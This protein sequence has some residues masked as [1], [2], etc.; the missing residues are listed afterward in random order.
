MEL[1][2]LQYFLAVTRE[3]SI[4]SAAQSLHLSQPTLSRQLK[5]LENELGKTLFIRSNRK[6]TLT[7]EGII[8]R[9]RAEEILELIQKAQNEI[10]LSDQLIAGNLYI[11]AGETESVRELAQ[12]AQLLQQKHPMIQFHI[13]SGDRTTVLDD[14]DH[15]M[16][17]FALVF[18]E[19]DPTRY[20]SLILPQ[21]DCFG[22]LMQKSDPLAKKET[23]TPED[24]M[25]KPL[26]V[27][28]QMLL[29]H[30]LRELFEC[31]ESEL[32]VVGTYNLLF[33]GS[34][35]VDEGMG[36]AICF[37]N[38]INVSGDSNLCFRPL[39]V[40]IAPKISLIWKKYQLLTKP[41]EKFLL[42]L[43]QKMNQPHEDQPLRKEIAE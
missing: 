21:K 41:A 12:V 13:I 2:V 14:L 18:G 33:N 36:Y 39:S 23:I 35:M 15:G 4:S 40:R 10:T 26:I 6:I 31:D 1:R 28:R 22:V 11:G 34:L 43:Q 7:Q 32:Y 38:I 30:H 5:D 16:I 37:D 27:S 3:E 9:K 25:H 19:I 20:D 42:M 8:L 24:L 29:E 17:D